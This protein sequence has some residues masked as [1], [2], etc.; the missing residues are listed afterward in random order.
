[1]LARGVASTT[2][3]TPPGVCRLV[4]PSPPARRIG[5]DHTAEFEATFLQQ[6]APACWRVPN[7]PSL[8]ETRGGS[9]SVLGL[10]R[11]FLADKPKLRAPVHDIEPRSPQAHDP[12]FELA[13]E[14]I[15]PIAYLR[16]LIEGPIPIHPPASPGA[17]STRLDHI[18]ID[19]AQDL[20]PLALTVL[21]AHAHQVTVLGDMNQ[22][23]YAHRGSRSWK[24]IL[25]SLGSRPQQIHALTPTYRSTKQI[26]ELANHIVRVG[27]LE[28]GVC[29]SF[30]RTG[31]E[32]RLLQ[33]TD[34]AQV[35]DAVIALVKEACT[36]EASTVAVLTRT[37][38]DARQL[39]D[40]FADR[41]PIASACITD[42]R[43]A[44]DGRAYFMPAYLAKGIEFDAVVV[45]DVDDVSYTRTTNDA[46]LLYVA[47]TR[48]L[49]RLV[50]VWSGMPSPLIAGLVRGTVVS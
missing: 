33:A 25:P 5:D 2:W 48:A 34:P 42:R 44:L 37:A 17:R 6:P 38:S 31:S 27:G 35:A 50:I 40:S 8:H 1:M 39:F 19:E 11:R 20:S 13:L 16:L 45:T 47:V 36:D 4:Q 26:A 3:H 18:V 14:D 32:P 28:G 46:T 7:S 15:A 9:Y 21:R 22:A 30:P 24:G 29:R 12:S 23:I 41:L 43:D 10:Y 49:H